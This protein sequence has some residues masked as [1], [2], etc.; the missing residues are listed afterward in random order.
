MKLIPLSFSERVGKNQGREHLIAEKIPLQVN[1][2]SLS[3]CLAE[4]RIFWSS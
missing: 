4:R 2:P 3:A 1:T